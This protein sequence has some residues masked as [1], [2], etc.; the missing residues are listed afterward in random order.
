MVWYQ[1][2]NKLLGPRR[3]TFPLFLLKSRRLVT[4]IS[5][6]MAIKGVTIT[7][8]RTIITTIEKARTIREIGTIEDV[9]VVAVTLVTVRIFTNRKVTT[10]RITMDLEHFHNRDI[11]LISM[12]KLPTM[13]TSMP[14]HQPHLITSWPMLLHSIPM[15][16]L[17]RVDMGM[18]PQATEEA[19]VE[20][21]TITTIVED[22]ITMA[23]VMIVQIDIP[24]V[25]MCLMDPIIVVTK[26]DPI[27]VMND[28]HP[29]IVKD[30]AGPVQNGGIIPM[31]VP[32]P[33]PA[34]SPLRV[35]RHIHQLLLLLA[36]L[37]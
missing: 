13:H 37:D 36:M 8:T 24:P 35:P 25:A 26:A 11:S 22:S 3:Q 28:A 20:A 23:T 21:V 4:T 29:A 27:L 30:T 14:M 34:G 33:R 9:D 18:D 6:I 7:T 17:N 15:G 16:L 19:M 1:L 10:I 12:I 5:R 31:I 32:I 2:L